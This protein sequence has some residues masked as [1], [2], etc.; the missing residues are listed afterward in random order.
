[1]SE[2]MLHTLDEPRTSI[3]SAGEISPSDL[4][5]STSELPPHSNL[6]LRK[7]SSSP[8]QSDLPN[9]Y[10]NLRAIES[11]T[12]TKTSHGKNILKKLLRINRSSDSIGELPAL[13]T[14]STNGSASAS[15][16]SSSKGL[17]RGR[18]IQRSLIL[19]HTDS[20]LEYFGEQ[21]DLHPDISKSIG[22]IKIPP[23]FSN[24]GLP[25]LKVSHKSKKRILFFIDPTSFKFMWRV[26]NGQAVTSPTTPM[27]ASSSSNNSASTSSGGGGHRLSISSA[28]SPHE[29]NIDDIKSVYKQKNGSSYREE[30]RISKE[31]ENKWITI[32]YF[33]QKK[34]NLKS[35]HLIA[36]SEHDYKKL[37][38]AVQNLRNLRFQLAK[39]FLIDLN[40]LDENYMKLILNE[41]L[42]QQQQ[43]SSKHIRE[44]LSFNDILKYVKRL[45]INVNTTHLQQIFEQ[46]SEGGGESTFEHG[47]NFDQFKQFVSILKERKDIQRIIEKQTRGKRYMDHSDVKKFIKHTQ[48]DDFDNDTIQQIFEKFA[49]EDDVWTS[50]S[51][52]NFLMSSYSKPYREIET[53]HYYDHPLSDYFISSSHNTYLTGRQVVGESS[54]DGYIRALQRGCKCV[55]IDIWNGED[56]SDSEPVVNHGR[57]FTKPIGLANVIRTIKKFAFITSPYPVILSLEIHCS[58]QSQLKVV[59]ILKDILKEDLVLAPIDDTPFLPSPNELKHKFIIKVKKT[60]AF[61][62][63]V[64]MDNGSFTTSSTSTSTSQSEDN[65]TSTSKTSSIIPRRKNKS[66][67]VINELSDLGVYAQGLKFRNFSL[68]ESKTYNHCFSLGEKTINRILKDDS[69]KN[70]LVKHNRKFLMRVYPGGTRI[71]STNYLP[72][73]YWSVGCQLV[74]TNWQTMDQGQML[75]L[76]M[77]SANYNRG[78]VL[79]SSALRKPLLSSKISTLLTQQP[80]S[81]TKSKFNFVVIS[82]HQLPKPKS[83]EDAVFTPPNI[84]ITFEI[85]GA[86]NVDW[87]DERSST[88]TSTN[89]VPENGFNPVF[90]A[91]FSGEMTV[92]NDLVFVKFVIYACTSSL[93][94]D[95]GELTPVGISVVKIDHLKQ[96]FRC[97]PI[98]DL[99]GEQLLYSSLFV[100]VHY[101]SLE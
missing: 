80:K 100:Y 97:L 33:N 35:L 22:N 42:Q 2:S 56:A 52:N 94:P 29:F 11:E 8:I 25:L 86:D 72:L 84:Y 41:E 9:I 88:S 44:F 21:V 92:L 67:K 74:A 40:N 28:R 81:T 26:T 24:E 18:S 98:Y 90:N 7:S 71:N 59:S 31:F 10:S 73:P 64:E 34:G 47:L 57:T 45:N 38:T 1:M 60:T 99:L 61:E 62:N 37:N 55:E 15:S 66:P 46:V 70:Q 65:G 12:P 82:A 76:A 69:A 54:V 63:L 53:K 20:D 79:K 39:E 58:A 49:N 89:I 43:Q 30:L 85:I 96:G 16:T 48:K 78:Y 36:D 14:P 32:I 101:D 13:A 77:F 23:T 68:P 50:E 91:K 93:H 87:D 27:T 5:F 51:L 19:Q 95:L 75:N 6:I 3:D 83:K 4:H 17:K